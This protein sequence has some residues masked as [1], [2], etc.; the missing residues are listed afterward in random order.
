[1]KKVFL[2]TNILLEIVLDRKEKDACNQI[3]QAGLNKEVSLFASYLTFA[4]MAYVLKKNKVS[5]EHVYQ[6]GQTM[7]KM[8][9]VLP[10]D[11][12]Q[13][14]AALQHEVNDFEDMLQHQCAVA[15]Q[16]D[17]IVNINTNDFKE[18]S[19]IPVYS[20]DELLN[21]LDEEVKP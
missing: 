15:G 9:T 10:M 18:F 1:M 7:E 20:P 4:N 2:D 5:R 3:I 16:S 8:M 19:T 11:G 14:R 17:C 13:L 6:I 12:D 21:M